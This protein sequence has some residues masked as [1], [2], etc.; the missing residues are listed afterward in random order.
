MS[1]WPYVVSGCQHGWHSPGWVHEGPCESPEGCLHAAHGAT[2]LCI[3]SG[4]SGKLTEADPRG[5]SLSSVRGTRLR[6]LC[7]VEGLEDGIGQWGITAVL[8][9]LERA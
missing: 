1:S 6:V 4:V 5:H 8:R 3:T 7:P 2:Q 9:A